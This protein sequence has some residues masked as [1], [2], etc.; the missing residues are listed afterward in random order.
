MTDLDELLKLLEEQAKDKRT[1]VKA[2]KSSQESCQR[3][4]N[5]NNIVKGLDRVPNYV[6]YYTYMQVYRGRLG[7]EKRSKNHFFRL[8]NKGFDQ[9]RTGKQRYYKL[10]GKSFDLTRGGLLEA[11]KYNEEYQIKVKKARGTLPK[12]PRSD[13]G[14]KRKSFNGKVPLSHK[15]QES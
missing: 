10:D 13:K 1:K 2:V 12:K 11:K 4:I 3:F 8:F 9:A 15:K 5:N 7:E 6:I 14:S